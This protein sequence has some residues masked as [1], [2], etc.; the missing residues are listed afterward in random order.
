MMIMAQVK[1]NMAAWGMAASLFFILACGLYAQ[2][3]KEE[4]A[5]RKTVM[6]QLEAN[7]LAVSLYGE[8]LK[9]GE[10]LEM[11]KRD[12]V[13]LKKMADDVYMYGPIQSYVQRMVKNAVLLHSAKEQ[14]YVLSESERDYYLEGLKKNLKEQLSEESV[15][16]VLSRYPKVGDGLFKPS[17]DDVLLIAKLN[18]KLVDD[19]KA[20]DAEV[21]EEENRVKAGNV[22]VKAF[23]QQMR[24]DMAKI[25]ARP[26]S[27]TDV[28]FAAL[29]KQYSEGIE[30]E[31]GGVLKGEFPRQLIE[32]ACDLDDFTLK[33]GETS[34]I[35]ESQTA[36]RALRVLKVL[37]P[38][39]EGGDELLRIAQIILPKYPETE[40]MPKEKLREQLINRKKMKRLEEYVLK[41]MASSRFSCP[42]FPQGLLKAEH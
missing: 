19:I 8:D 38:K 6:A 15:Q 32:F 36:F 14:G 26:E 22:A 31:D 28:G 24:S 41:Q 30:A 35:L 37:P 1:R 3:G 23:N 10:L 5:Q 29:A 27:K 7:D 34:G 40:E 42:L 18:A 4:T 11:M 16:A 2:E 25:L 21:E 39:V 33:E 12:G 13:P 20:T 17:L 9:W